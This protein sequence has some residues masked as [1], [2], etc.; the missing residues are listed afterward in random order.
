MRTVFGRAAA[1]T[2]PVTVYDSNRRSDLSADRVAARYH[3]FTDD[4]PCTHGA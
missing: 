4:R 3:L 1:H 2:R